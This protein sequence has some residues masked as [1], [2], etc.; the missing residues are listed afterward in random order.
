MNF[1]TPKN[2]F[3]TNLIAALRRAGYFAIVD[4]L[5]GKTGYVRRLSREAH[6]PR[7]HLYLYRETPQ[8]YHF[9]LHLDQKRP[10]YRGSPAHSADYHEDTVKVEL[11]RVLSI[12][13][14]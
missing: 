7:F 2:Q 14:N 13:K 9:S 3:K 10:S 5:T 1:A 6:F 12:L 4:R 8:D 11:N